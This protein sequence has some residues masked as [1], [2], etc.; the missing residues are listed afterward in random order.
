M[1]GRMAS[2]IIWLH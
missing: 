1:F 2:Y